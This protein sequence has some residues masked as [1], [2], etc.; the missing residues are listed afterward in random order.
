L[1]LRGYSLAEFEKLALD[2]RGVA[3]DFLELVNLLL[4]LLKLC[5]FV[6]PRLGLF[7]EPLQERTQKEEVVADDDNHYSKYPE[8]EYVTIVAT[9]RC[10]RPACLAYCSPAA[11]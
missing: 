10:P 9:H 11:L 1:R 2:L 4:H 5:L 6:L 7:V 8:D 3:P